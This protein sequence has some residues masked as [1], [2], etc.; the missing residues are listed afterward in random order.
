MQQAELTKKDLVTDTTKYL[1]DIGQNDSDKIAMKYLE[2]KNYNEFAIL[3]WIATSGI[4]E[5]L[6]EACVN[7]KGRYLNSNA[8]YIMELLQYYHPEFMKNYV[9]NRT[10]KSY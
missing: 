3:I 1:K 6:A 2:N 9:S 5:G 7:D 10:N 8:P 4:L